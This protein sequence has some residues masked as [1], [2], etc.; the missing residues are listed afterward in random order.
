[1]YYLFVI[2]EQLVCNERTGDFGAPV[3]CNPGEVVSRVCTSGRDPDCGGYYTRISCCDGS[4]LCTRTLMDIIP[5]IYT[6]K[7]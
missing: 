2:L 3:L 4:Y 1:V 5:Q 6:N 7:C